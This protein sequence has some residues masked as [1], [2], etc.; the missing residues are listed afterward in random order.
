MFP[1]VPALQGPTAV[2]SEDVLLLGH[3]SQEQV[4]LLYLQYRKK[5]HTRRCLDL[6]LPSCN[7]DPNYPDVFLTNKAI[8]HKAGARSICPDSHP[9]GTCKKSRRSQVPRCG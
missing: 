6:L 1:N 3:T 9:A 5:N 2:N 8:A 4:A 7:R